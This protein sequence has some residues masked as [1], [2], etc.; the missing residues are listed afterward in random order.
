M[1][2]AFRLSLCAALALPTTLCLSVL[3]GNF[4]APACRDKIV[5]PFSNA[6]IWNMPIGSDAEYVPSGIVYG[7]KQVFADV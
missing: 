1:G 2:S 7:G 3:A 5:W 6:S 4:A